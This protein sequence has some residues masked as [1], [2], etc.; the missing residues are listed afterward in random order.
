MTTLAAPPAPYTP[1]RLNHEVQVTLESTFG[2][3]EI[4]GEISN[5]SRPASGHW[6]FTLKDSKAQVRCAMFRGRNARVKCEVR[7]GLQ[8]KLRARVSLYPDRG[9]FQLIVDSLE[10]AGEGALRQAYE[11]L[12]KKLEAEG[13]FDA[14]RKR[15]LPALPRHI[16]LIT[17]A[18]GAA[19][20]DLLTVLRRRWPAA[21]LTLIPTAVQGERAPEEIIAAF[22]KLARWYEDDPEGAPELVITGRGGGSLEDLWA[23]NDEGVARALVACPVPVV[24]AVGHESDVS[25]ADFVADLRAP[26][27]SAAA[28][29]ATP[30]GDA[31]AHQLE[32][33]S[34][35]LRRALRLTFQQRRDRLL[36][37]QRQLPNPRPRLERLA[38]RLD[39]LENQ[40][41]QGLRYQ[42]R[43]H[44]QRLKGLEHRLRNAAPGQR[45]A[46]SRD[47]AQSLALRLRQA[48]PLRQITQEQ[49]ALARTSQALGDALQQKQNSLAQRLALAAQG[50]QLQSPLGTVARGYA[51]LTTEPEAGKRFG[52]VIKNPK[53]IAPGTRLLAAL[54]EGTLAVTAEGPVSPQKDEP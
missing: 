4:E 36:S 6:Y 32:R 43:D 8:A 42:Q 3:I 19:I 7:N 51:V 2:L 53:A 23:F 28:E 25:I 38:Q 40:L 22:R 17:S 41:R 31:L 34:G 26:T 48:A 5:F 14:A 50:L 44:H 12:R 37:L 39:G 45:L 52:T 13:L 30:D 46:R 35:R 54:A 49:A 27:P 20:H 16:A 29:L 15:P 24:A 1:S 10:P 11:A 21:T 18:T 33:Q 9:E 47:R